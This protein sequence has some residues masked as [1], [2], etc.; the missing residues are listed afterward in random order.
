[1]GEGGGWQRGGRVA[2]P[3]LAEVQKE[4][5]GRVAGVWVQR[6]PGTLH[7]ASSLEMDGPVWM[8]QV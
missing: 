4:G 8:V 2:G 7:R 6:R 5:E 3:V 1:M